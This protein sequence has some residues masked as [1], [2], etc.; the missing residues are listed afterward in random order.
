MTKDKIQ[1]ARDSGYSDDEI[2]QYLS[3]SDEQ[4]KKAIEAG[5]SIDEVSAYLDAK[6]PEVKEEPKPKEEEPK[7]KED[8]PSFGQ[9]VGGLGAN[10]AISEGSKIAGTAAGAK[11]GA[12]SA[13]ALGQA[14][15]QALLPEELVTVP[16]AATLGA[17]IGYV[18]SSIGGGI[19][20]DVAAQKIEGRDNINWIRAGL[21]GV[22]N[23]IPGAKITKGPQMLQRVSS[24][25]AKSPIVS[26]AVVGSVFGP[27]SVAAES[28]YETGELPETK[29]VV[30]AGLV[31]SVLGGGLGATQKVGQKLLGRFAGKTAQEVEDLVNAGDRGAIAYVDALTANV[32]PAE[33]MTASNTKAY[34]QSL[35]DTTKSRIAP[36]KTI[37]PKAT[38]AIRDAGNIA[39]AG[40]EVGSFLGNRVKDAIAKSPNPAEVEGIA[41]DYLNGKVS[42]LP[43]GLENLAGDL[44]AARKYI[45]EYQD[46]LLKN[47]Y[48]GQRPLPDYLRTA[49]EESKNN[50]D[51][52]TRSYRFFED[53]DYKPTQKQTDAAFNYLKSTGMDEKQANAYLAELNSKRAGTV[54]DAYNFFFGSQN[55]GVLKE[56]K[57]VAP[58]IREYL[59]EFTAPGEKI[60]STMSK[61][62]RLVAY[63]TSDNEIAKAL[64]ETGALKTANDPASKGLI[65]IKLR[66]GNAKISTP[67]GEEI[68]YGTP[69]VQ[70]AINQLYGVDADGKAIDIADTVTKDAWESM[71]SA[72]K[73]TKVLLNPPAYLVQVYGNMH[74]VMGM[75]M[76]PIKGLKTGLKMGAAQFADSPIGKIPGFRKLAANID[77]PSL[78]QFKRYKEMGLVPQGLQFADMQA[79]LTG[80]KIG[81]ATQKFLDPFGKVYSIPDIALRISAYENNLS[82]LS[83]AASGASA[84]K[85]LQQIIEKRA[86]DLTNST[87]VNYDYINKSVRTLSRKGVINP[88]FAF[89]A[90][91]F[92]TQYN[93]G[94]LALSMINGSFAK[95]LQ[96][97]LGVPINDKSLRIEGAKKI[98]ALA[99]LYGA[100]SYGIDKFNRNTISS[101]E[102]RAYRETIAP[103]WDENRPMALVK[104]GD[105]IQ[106]INSSYIVP[107][108]QMIGPFLSAA[109]GESMQDAFGKF[110][111]TFIQDAAGEGSFPFIVAGQALANHSYKTGAPI[112]YDPAMTGK[113]AD[114]SQFFVKELFEPGVM[115]EIEKARTQ[116]ISTTVARQAGIR[117]N[118]TTIADGFRFKANRAKQ[119]LNGISENVAYQRGKLERNQIGQDEFSA[120]FAEQDNEFKKQEQELIKHTRNLRTLGKT[121]DE[122]I[123]MMKDSGIG[124]SK[125]LNAIEGR[126]VGISITPKDTTLDKYESLT[127]RTNREKEL[128]I[129]K[130][131]KSDPVVAR[132][133]LDYH[134]QI[135]K[136]DILDIKP[137]DKLVRALPIPERARYIFDRMNESESPDGVFMQFYKK[138]VITSDTA[139]A[140]ELLKKGN[141]KY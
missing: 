127:G 40:R 130:M 115:R 35:A 77:V 65:E 134:K 12:A 101:D 61:L 24:A 51:Y 82:M 129:S 42:K 91:M 95:S 121:D 87:Y 85:A 83:K 66:R 70:Y 79:G 22:Q 133:L 120:R 63:D 7:P 5:Y 110:S 28:Y 108:M 33:F 106:S 56:R 105:K 50:G 71:V 25:A 100:Y 54:D 60:S 139:R 36:S 46:D 44:S 49:I 122:I 109:R 39:M 37:G 67:E 20:G 55:A 103:E 47:H 135:L 8:E 137:K 86:A 124:S 126:S 53:A 15:P 18:T 104:N 23:L 16:A 138:G 93:Q 98:A 32:D 34:F 75:A 59:G 107:H 117:I 132:K 14:G 69:D 89:Q 97:E 13:L 45:Q 72:S 96:D 74:N 2:A 9:I 30:Q 116:P 62:S 26:N 1:A 58:E 112:S 11:I 92:R 118:E 6:K 78:D 31:T 3:S 90:E 119:A 131:F 29:D 41:L 21:N 76:N 52:L 128:E 4:Y 10:I 94:K 136:D 64:L 123:N 113:V 88:F 57:D 111:E 27:A 38:Q 125:I 140:I 102:E 80:N 99:S 19:M 114:I 68:L 17:G 73:A 43:E 48:N 84:D 141:G 81:K